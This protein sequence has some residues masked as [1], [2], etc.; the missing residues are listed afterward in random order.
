MTEKKDPRSPWKPA[1]HPSML[2]VQKNGM[3]RMKA[4]NQFV[5]EIVK[6]HNGVYR[7]RTKNSAGKWREH[8]SRAAFRSIR[9]TKK[10]ICSWL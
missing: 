5:A 8:F 7:F 3:V 2:V 9:D 4:T 1:V 6:D 10:E